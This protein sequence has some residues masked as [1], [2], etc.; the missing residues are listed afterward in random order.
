MIKPFRRALPCLLCLALLAAGVCLLFWDR[1]ATLASVS[2]LGCGDLLVIV[3]DG[4]NMY[5]GW[6]FENVP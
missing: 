6:R 4:A 2:R 1:H 5:P 3:S